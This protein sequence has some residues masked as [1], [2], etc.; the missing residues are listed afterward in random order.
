MRTLG[1]GAHSFHR[2]DVEGLGLSFLFPVVSRKKCANS[3]SLPGVRF[4]CSRESV[5]YFHVKWRTL[6][7]SRNLS[8]EGLL[9]FNKDQLYLKEE[10]FFLC[11][12]A[13][14]Q[15]HLVLP[16][17]PVECQIHPSLLKNQCFIFSL[18]YVFDIHIVDTWIDFN[19]WIQIS[20]FNVQNHRSFI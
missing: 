2:L 20:A 15:P 1:S 9:K 8:F 17:L 16:A 10:F 11:W 19:W 14:L 13:F 7:I 6:G 5:K 18:I 12:R 3:G 4:L